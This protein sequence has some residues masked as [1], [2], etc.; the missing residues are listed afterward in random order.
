ML[1]GHAFARDEIQPI[2]VLE[3]DMEKGRSNLYGVRKFNSRKF[4]V[5]W[6]FFRN[7]SRCFFLIDLFVG[8]SKTEKEVVKEIRTGRVSKENGVRNNLL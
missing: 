3:E 5:L 2:R 4:D 1:I 7:W 8:I 6:R